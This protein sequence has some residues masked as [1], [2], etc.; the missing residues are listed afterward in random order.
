V[1]VEPRKR[2]DSITK[3][4]DFMRKLSGSKERS[5]SIRGKMGIEQQKEKGAVG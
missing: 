2:E 4:K 1:Q 3:I 5:R